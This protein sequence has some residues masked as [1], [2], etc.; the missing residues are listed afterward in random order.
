MPSQPTKTNRFLDR[1]PGWLSTSETGRAR[2]ERQVNNSTEETKAVGKILTAESEI[3]WRE[4]DNDEA[5]N[6]EAAAR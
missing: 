2:G 4:N 5:M 6:V 3:A 1:I